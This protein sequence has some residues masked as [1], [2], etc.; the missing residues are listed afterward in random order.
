MIVLGLFVSNSY[1]NKD[2]IERPRI[3][4]FI[5]ENGDTIRL[6]SSDYTKLKAYN[7]GI[8]LHKKKLIKAELEFETGEILTFESDRNN[9]WTHIKLSN[10]KNELEFPKST[11]KKISEIHF[12]SVALLW[13]GSDKDA[14]S[15]EYSCIQ[16]DIT[17]EKSFDKFPYLQL[18]FADKK[19]TNALIWRQTSQNST[20]GDDF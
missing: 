5:F 10:K 6:N 8:I 2:R 7:S 19:F 15:A 9:N 11:L 18:R 13:N 3:Y 4:I 16:F 1:A 20:Q 14:F 12:S 17:A